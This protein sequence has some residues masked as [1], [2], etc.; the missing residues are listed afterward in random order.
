L[1]NFYQFQHFNSVVLNLLAERQR[2]EIQ[3]CD[4][5]RGPQ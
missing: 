4:F 2:S 3:I 5:V 1:K